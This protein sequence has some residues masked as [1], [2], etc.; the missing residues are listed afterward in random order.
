MADDDR[1]DGTVTGE[2]ESLARY[3]AGES[4]S[5]ERARVEAELAASPPRAALLAALDAVLP[6]LSPSA[7]P[8]DEVERALARVL[9]RR[10]EAQESGPLVR[11]IGGAR[12][13]RTLWRAARLRA[14]AAVVLVA[15]GALLLRS[16]SRSAARSE[17]E[18]GGTQ[19][20]RQLRTGVGVVDSVRLPDGSRVILGPES[21][22]RIPAGFSRSARSVALRGQ[23]YFDVVHDA[24]HPLEVLTPT[25]ELRDVGTAFTVRDEADTLRVVVVSG[26][27]ALRR[28]GPGTASLAT[29]RAG[30]R[31]VLPAVGALRVERDAE[32]NDALAWTARRLAFRDAKVA[33]VASELRRWY[34]VELRVSD[35]TLQARR[36]TASFE[37][38][39]RDDVGRVVA[40]ALG[41]VARVRGDTLWIDRVPAPTTRR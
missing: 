39:T 38:A 20:E 2:W 5:A 36:L 33:E 26:A 12:G 29:L 18:A 13:Y 25:A 22:L 32:V 24:A 19:A 15:G 9:A 8:A 34:G 23:G 16:T 11:P 27:V 14:A 6:P 28:A 10:G 37:H 21:E 35:P 1:S 30:E 17:L 41:G 40:A 3:A 4:D 31:G 7:I